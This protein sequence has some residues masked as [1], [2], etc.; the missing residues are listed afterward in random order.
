M[1]INSI[2]LTIIAAL[3]GQL[4]QRSRQM[5]PWCLM[6]SGE[7]SGQN[8]LM[9][10]YITSSTLGSLARSFKRK[11]F[12]VTIG[13][14]GS[15]TLRLMIVFASGLVRLEYR[16][17]THGRD[18]VIEDIFD[19]AKH[20][21]YPQTENVLPVTIA[22]NYWALL[23]YGLTY[24]HGTTSRFAVQSFASGNDGKSRHSSRY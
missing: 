4:E 9:L 13:I 23:K 15:L 17:M 8:S 22:L 18:L 2:V 14:C 6:R 24:P 7:V 10:N 21:D 11:H 16:S 19:L 5:M 12:L 1:L 20:V 3:W